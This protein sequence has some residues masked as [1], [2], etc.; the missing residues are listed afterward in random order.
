MSHG[1]VCAGGAVQ[2]ADEPW[3]QAAPRVAVAAS[4]LVSES[5][6][7]RLGMRGLPNL[8]LLCCLRRFGGLGLVVWFRFGLRQI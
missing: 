2:E 1:Y 6:R 3:Q 4:K 5:P 8:L 7:I